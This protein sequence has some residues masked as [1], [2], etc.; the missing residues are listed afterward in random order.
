MKL[1]KFN[2]LYPG[3]VSSLTQ[4]TLAAFA[5]TF[6][7]VTSVLL[8]T[9]SVRA[10]STNVIE[11][12]VVTARKREESL[13][14][15]PV[16]VSVLTSAMLDSQRI[17]GIRDLGTIVPGLITTEST[18]S[19]AGLVFLR[20]VGSGSLTPLIDQAVS[21]NVDGVGISSASLMNAGMFDLDRIEVLR[22][23][24]ALFYGKNSP[25]GV[26]ALHTKDP[27]DEFEFEFSALYETEGE[28][29]IVRAIISGPLGETLRGR[30]SAGWSDADHSRF[31]AHNLDVFETGP[32]GVPVQMAHATP[33]NPQQTE[34]IYVIGT[35]LWEPTDK[36]SA[37]L[38][39]AHLEDN[40][41]GHTIFN[42]QR[43]QCGLGVPQVFYPVPGVDNCKMDGNVIAGGISPLLTAA[44]PNHPGYEGLGFHENEEAFMSLE[45]KY[46]LSDTLTLTS[47]TGY[48]DQSDQ[49]IAESSFQA[50]VGLLNSSAYDK[51]QWSQELRLSSNLR[52]GVQLYSGCFLRRT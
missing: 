5:F 33:K 30:L 20:G 47:V 8:P 16:A 21:V 28:E 32:G 50:A 46:D 29:P 4:F 36:F 11:E 43:T 17:E 6:M 19:T 45:I 27:T 48:Y 42:F 1:S 35:L 23:P 15:V 52:W 9:H 40:Q 12:I 49:R 31:D 7:S 51:E 24:Q 10:E 14:E 2:D 39:Y 13:Q 38:K 37:K 41:D 18:S 25:G 22:G 26:V 44:D 34:K 3:E